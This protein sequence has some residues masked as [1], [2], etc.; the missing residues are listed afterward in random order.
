MLP[1][2][3]LFASIQGEN[4]T[5]YNFVPEMEFSDPLPLLGTKKRR[6]ISAYQGPLFGEVTL[7]LT[8]WLSVR[9]RVLNATGGDLNS[10]LQMTMVSGPLPPSINVASRFQTN[11]ATSGW[12]HDK[13]GF[14][15]VHATHNKC[16]IVRDGNVRPLAPCSWL[17]EQHCTRLEVQ[18]F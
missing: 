1:H 13:N 6:I 18:G 14:H 11:M 12:W 16:N 10:L 8:T 17:Q 5:I 15:P 3:F 4:D 9:Y 2:T 7:E